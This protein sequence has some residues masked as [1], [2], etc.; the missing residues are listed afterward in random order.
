MA[1][2]SVIISSEEEAKLLKPIDEY[3]EE[4]QKKIDALRADGFDKVSDLKKQI[5]IAKE[6][7]NLSATQR[8]KIIENSKKELENAKKVEADNKEEIK[9]L[10]AEAEETDAICL[11]VSEETGRLSVAIKGELYYNLSLDDV[12]MMLIDELKPKTNSTY[13]QEEIEEEG[14]LL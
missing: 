9:K 11:V 12:R 1:E 14:F 5:A 7:K 6:N 2:N 8:D 3:V 4:I 10:V 13:D